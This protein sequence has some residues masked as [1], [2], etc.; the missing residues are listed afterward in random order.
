METITSLQRTESN[1]E[2]GEGVTVR[3]AVHGTPVGEALFAVTGRGVCAIH[4]LD[5]L[6]NLK[7][8]LQTLRHNWPRAR[9]EKD[10]AATAPVAR[11]VSER[12]LGRPRERLAVVFRGTRFQVKVW[13]ALLAIPAGTVTTYG[14]VAARIGQPKAQRATAAAIGANAVGYL[15]PCH[16]VLRAT[17]AMGGYRWGV[18]RKKALLLMESNQREPA[19][20]KPVPGP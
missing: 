3:W 7:V 12:M 2:G 11:E 6:N 15:I 9:L 4:F 18:A 5:D 20:G 17:G 1:P 10:D 14:E 16:R 13:Q 19:A 8:L